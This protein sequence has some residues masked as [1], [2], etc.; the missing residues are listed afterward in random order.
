MSRPDASGQK[1]RMPE[2]NKAFMRGLGLVL[3]LIGMVLLMRST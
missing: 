2:Q 1:R 3:I